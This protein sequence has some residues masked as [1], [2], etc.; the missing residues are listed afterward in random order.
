MREIPVGGAASRQAAA[1]R[2]TITETAFRD[3]HQSLLATRMKTDDMLA[4]AEKVDEVGYF[5]LEVWGGATFD[6]CLR[7]LDEDPWDRLRALKARI[8]KTPLQMLL[9]GQ[10]LVGYHHYPDDVVDAFVTH[11]VECGIDIMRIFDALN[12]VRN[13]EKPM[14]AAKREGA[15]VQACV[16]YT[17][18]PVHDIEHYVTTSKTLENMGADSV[19]IKDM[20]GLIAPYAAYDLVRRMKETLSVPVQLHSHYTSGMASMAYLK[21]IEAG[22]DCVDTAISALALGTSQPPTETMVA[23]LRGTPYDTMLDLGA[24]AEINAHFARIKPNYQKVAAPVIVNAEALRW[25]IPG[26]MLS[27]LRAQLSSQGMLDKLDAVL[28][29]V[30]RVREEMGYP[31]LVTPMSQIVGTQA[32]L[33]VA[34]GERYGVKS[35]EIKDYVRGLYGRP[36]AP[37]SDEV[38]KMVIGDE[39]VV[40]IRPADLLEPELEKAREAVKDYTEKDEDVL[41]YIMFPEVAMDFFRKRAGKGD[42]SPV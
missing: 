39:E 10:N 2:V 5:S 13:M 38:R 20:A 25:Q 16:V 17:L 24:L 4:I 33:N 32:V 3:A 37:I 41:T 42:G 27:N 15:R 18:S 26:G 8:R 35:R 6:T 31:P 29:E 7:Y 1:R 28:A 14:E 9:R 21:A 11:A 19:C 12:D 23:A 40:T 36:P 34:T 22:V 30:P